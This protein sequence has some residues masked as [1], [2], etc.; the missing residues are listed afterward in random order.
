MVRVSTRS[1]LSFPAPPPM[2][3]YACD[4]P[5]LVAGEKYARRSGEKSG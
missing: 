2:G 3:M 4:R 5:P 1:V